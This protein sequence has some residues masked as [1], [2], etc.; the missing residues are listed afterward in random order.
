MAAIAGL[1]GT[2]DW[3]T[4]ERPKSFRE[5]IM[6]RMPNGDTPITALTSKISKEVVSDPEFNWWDEPADILRLQVNGALVAAD[7]TVVVDSTDPDT[8]TPNAVWGTAL[9]LVPGDIL[10]VE[11]A[12]DAAP[13]APEYIRVTQVISA[14]TFKVERGVGGG[15]AAG[16][17]GNDVY[18]LKVGSAFAEGSAAPASATRNPIKYT[19][20]CQIF[21]TTY[22]LTNTALVT[23]TRTGDPLANDKKRKMFDHARDIEFAIMFGKKYETTGSNGKP[24]R[25]TAGIRAQIPTATTTVFGAAVTISSFLDAVYPVFDYSTPGG[26][27]RIAFCG[28]KA[29]NKLNKIIQSD[30]NTSIQFN[31]QIKFYGMTFQ[32]FIL[33]QGRILLRTHPLLNR[34]SL[35]NDSMWLIDFSALRWRYTKGRDGVFKDNI[36]GNDEDTRKGQWLTEGGLEVRYGGLSCGYLGYISHA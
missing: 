9:H 25:Y 10:M 19:N 12:A 32:E 1:R 21:K 11:P 4:D 7:T 22:E 24:L 3:A 20:Y 23:T 28:N 8:T 27:T 2:G 15:A 33:P 26:D 16:N 14:T 31:S 18:L 5:Y 36:Q 34:H 13:F 29:L 35:Y 6:W 17:I 30:T